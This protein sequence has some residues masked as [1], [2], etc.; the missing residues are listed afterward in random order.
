[1][2]EGLTV[3][4]ELV[5][6]VPGLFLVTSVATRLLGVRRSWVANLTSVVLGS[7]SGAVIALVLAEGDITKHGYIRNTLAIAF[8]MTMVVSVGADMLA[9]PGTLAKGDQAGLFVLPRPISHARDVLDDFRRTREII[10]IVSHNGFGPSIGI[11][12]DPTVRPT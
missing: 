5:I 6:L 3:I 1:M 8:V 4:V 7:V 10:R 2:S 9:K 11:R 12:G